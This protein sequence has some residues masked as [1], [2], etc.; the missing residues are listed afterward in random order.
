[1]TAKG[2]F[3]III[4]GKRGFCFGSSRFFFFKKKELHNFTG[5][6]VVAK[7]EAFLPQLQA[8]LSI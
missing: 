3:K 4:C 8:S 2:L 6:A 1:M 7:F 5:N